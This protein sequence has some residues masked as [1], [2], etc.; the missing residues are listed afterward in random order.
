MPLAVRSAAA[1]ALLV[2]AVGA[3]PAPAPP[4]GA[5]PVAPKVY[6]QLRW[7]TIGPEGNR[8]SAAVGVPGDPLT[9]YVG[10]A[11]VDL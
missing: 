7:R 8:F 6:R 10:A 11:S 5:P 4:A 2:S 1:L 3:Q 9:Y